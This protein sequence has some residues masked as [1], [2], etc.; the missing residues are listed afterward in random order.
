[1]GGREGGGQPRRG[2]T[3]SAL[4]IESDISACLP[5]GWR[6]MREER[7]EGGVEPVGPEWMSWGQLAAQSGNFGGG[8]SCGLKGLY[9]RRPGSHLKASEEWIIPKYP[10]R[11]APKTRSRII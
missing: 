8:A 4:P 6:R 9:Q 11:D 3:S 1:M 10:Q 7:E 5:T 2:R